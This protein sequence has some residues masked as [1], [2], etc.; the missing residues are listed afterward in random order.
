MHTCIL[1]RFLGLDGITK[2]QPPPINVDEAEWI[3]IVNLLQEMLSYSLAGDDRPRTARDFAFSRCIASTLSHLYINYASLS[4]QSQSMVDIMDGFEKAMKALLESISVD[5]VLKASHA[6]RAKEGKRRICVLSSGVR[7]TMMFAPYFKQEDEIRG[8]KRKTW[9]CILSLL[10]RIADVGIPGLA[11][12][13][14]D[15]ASLKDRAIRQLASFSY[16]VFREGL[17]VYQQGK[18]ACALSATF[19]LL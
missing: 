1:E 14:D 12:H 7:T 5:Q 19:P 9:T 11:L 8:F 15:V 17:S 6:R 13:K 4:V 18:A 3:L 16:F 10:V 2:E